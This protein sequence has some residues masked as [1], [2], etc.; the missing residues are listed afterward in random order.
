[1]GHK[2][3]AFL[4][5]DFRT[6]ISYRLD[7]L[8]RLVGVLISVSVFYFLSQFLDSTVDTYLD[9]YGTDFF[10]YALMGL[11]FY[12]LIQMSSNSLASVVSGY[13]HSG[14]LEVLFL[15]PTPFMATL[16]FSTLWSYCWALGEALVYLLVASLLFR[17]DLSWNRLFAA[18]FVVLLAILANLG[19][20]LI[21]AGFVLVTKRSSPLTRFLSLITG[22]LA[23]AFFPV[24]ILPE[25]LRAFSY[26]LPATYAFDALRRT[27]IQGESLADIRLNLLALLGFI[28][29][30][31][32]LGFIVFRYAER[33][34]K[35]DGS[36][37][38]F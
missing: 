22:L 15:S 11:A 29:V 6:Q 24:A 36:L 8:M 26:L 21:N 18:L 3:A 38:Q 7:F 20:G 17:A 33:W 1:M 13:Q 16:L 10:H 23:G 34:A 4:R 37:A 30:L 27:L 28:V 12:P 9:R 25:W 5:R 2:A 32:P 14:T 19:L 35:T 31:M